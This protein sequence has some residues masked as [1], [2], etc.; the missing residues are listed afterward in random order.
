MND[1]G[2][3]KQQLIKELA[4]MRRRVSQ[5]EE[6]EAGCQHREDALRE[7]EKLQNA[8]LNNVGAYIYL[9]DTQYRYTYV[10]NKV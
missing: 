4:T 6:S 3:T 5:L 1:N 2:K 8:I 10:N 9:K 7:S